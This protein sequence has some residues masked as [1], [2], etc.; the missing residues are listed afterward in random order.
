M[1]Q[2]RG[3]QR[4]AVHST[5]AVAACA[6]WMLHQADRRLRHVVRTPGLSLSDQ[7][8]ATMAPSGSQRAMPEP[9]LHPDPCPCPCQGARPCPWSRKSQGACLRLRP[10]EPAVPQTLCRPSS[11]PETMG[12]LLTMSRT[13]C[14]LPAN[15][16]NHQKSP[17]PLSFDLSRS[18]AAG[19]TAF[20]RACLLHLA[21]W[22]RR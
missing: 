19:T 2:R 14:G 10:G 6:A 1:Q 16:A 5:L 11:S 17:L 3:Q 13:N 9:C 18:Q 12:G 20:E 15:R 8:E 21:C 4:L 7:I 22:R